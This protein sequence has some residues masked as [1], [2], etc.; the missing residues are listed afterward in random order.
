MNS[1]REAE[2]KIEEALSNVRDHSSVDA[3]VLLGKTADKVCLLAEALLQ[4]VKGNKEIMRLLANVYVYDSNVFTHSL[5]VTVYSLLIGLKTNMNEKDLQTLG[6][7]AILHDV[8]KMFIPCEIMMKPGKLT[9][10]EFIQIQKHAEYGYE[11]IRSIPFL[12][13]EI[14]ICAHQ[15]HERLDGSG[16]PNRLTAE[17]IHPFAQIIAIADV[18]DAVTSNRVYRSAMLPFEGLE[19]LNA[20]AGIQFSQTILNAFRK[21]VA[22]YP[23]GLRVELNDGRKGK[24]IA[25]NSLQ[26]DRPIIQIEIEACDAE[27]QPDVDLLAQPHLNI[28]KAAI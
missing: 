9:E 14:S 12:S 16:Y 17:E 20:G 10:E 25:Q 1:L 3:S 22:F 19:I 11:L 27:R 15:H 4:E 21:S 6:M 5:N 2:K 13:P 28:V 18:Y 7:G 23:N 24:V 26:G 8:G